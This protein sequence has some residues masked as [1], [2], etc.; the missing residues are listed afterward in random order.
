VNTTQGQLTFTVNL[1]VSGTPTLNVNQTALNFPFR[2]ALIILR[3]N[4][5]GNK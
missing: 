2:P 4:C 3:L 1:T 5:F